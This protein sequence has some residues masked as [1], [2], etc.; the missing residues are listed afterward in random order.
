V[1]DDCEQKDVKAMFNR[2]N[3]QMKNN[4]PCIQPIGEVESVDLESSNMQ[5]F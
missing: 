3:V 5:S 4:K 1:I 2:L